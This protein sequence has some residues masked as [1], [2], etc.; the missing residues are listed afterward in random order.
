L[1]V[2]GTATVA[3]IGNATG[4]GTAGVTVDVNLTPNIAIVWSIGISTRMSSITRVTTSLARRSTEAIKLPI[5]AY[6]TTFA[7]FTTTQTLAAI[8]AAT[9]R[10]L[11]STA[12][13][14]FTTVGS[15]GVGTGD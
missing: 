13:A 2:T 14:A 11:P 12:V 4:T 3:T 5:A 10:Y 15:I 1:C 9:L 6:E 8:T 7:G